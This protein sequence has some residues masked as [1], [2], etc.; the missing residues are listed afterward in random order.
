[1][2][3][4][5][6]LAVCVFL[7]AGTTPGFCLRFDPHPLM[8]KAGNYLEQGRFLECIQTYHQVY[9]F[10]GDPGAQK[11]A[12]VRMADVLALFAGQKQKALDFYEQAIREFSNSTP[13][14][15]NAY[16]NSAML[17]YELGRMEK[18]S[19]RFKAFVHT[20]SGSPRVFTAEYMLER[21]KMERGKDKEDEKNET[22]KEESIPQV[23]VSLGSDFPL[24]VSL[25]HGGTL[26]FKGNSRQLPAGEYSFDYRGG[27]FVFQGRAMGSKAE[28]K[29]TA[30]FSLGDNKYSGDIL[31]T[32]SRKDPVL[33]NKLRLEKYL[34]GVVPREMSP[35]WSVQALK[36]QAVAAR[37]YA[38]YL[39]LHSRDKPYDVAATTASQVYGG[40]EAGNPTTD[41][42]VIQT[43]GE[44]LV[45][46]G[47][48]ILSYFHSHSGGV[49][50][51]AGKVWTTSLPYYKVIP[52][53]VS[54]DYKDLSWNTA[55]SGSDLARSL[56]R[57]GF[58]PTS[59]LNVSPAERSSSGRISR[60]RISTDQE[61]FEISSNSLRIWLGAGK[62]KSTLCSIEKR[63]GEY[64]F[65]GHG[66][67]HGVG[68]SQ[69]GA[70]GMAENGEG[71]QRILEHYYP[72]TEL[73]KLW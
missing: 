40:A 8:R 27:S 15:E 50:E 72:Q 41:K 53:P 47:K 12:L 16:F 58:E 61:D 17:Y 57:N 60:V 43:R 23:R 9:E 33:V 73:R 54:M 21:I 10:A 42:A 34:L 45:Y 31:F 62:I 11:K 14:L 36:A 48:P 1:M 63:G 20:Y 13:G 7:L 6:W 39:V 25:S 22:I 68:M 24:R 44:V 59:I 28:I 56:R 66:F 67:G 2:K 46:K 5:A 51:D 19:S 35:S 52:D 69:W 71:Y 3:K 4:I 49:L 38:Y 70:Q 30:G 65:S 37:S 64:I 29:T 55:I 26:F 32:R 18:A